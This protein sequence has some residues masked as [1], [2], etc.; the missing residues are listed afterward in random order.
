MLKRKASETL[1]PIIITNHLDFEKIFPGNLLVG[2]LLLGE[3]RFSRLS[4]FCQVVVGSFTFIILTI[5]QTDR[6]FS[7]SVNSPLFRC[8]HSVLAF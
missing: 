1:A 4:R 5:K 8:I 2:W 6:D 3:W 7:D